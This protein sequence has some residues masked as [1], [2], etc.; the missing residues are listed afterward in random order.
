MRNQANFM[1]KTSIISFLFIFIA[2]YPVL[3]ETY[4]ADSAKVKII[5]D[6]DMGPDYDDIGAIALLH[7]FANQGKIEILATVSS[8]AHKDIPGTIEVYNKYFKRGDIPVGQTYSPLAPNFTAANNWN[9]QIIK[10][11]EPALLNKKY[12]SSVSIYRKVLA[13]QPDNSVTIVTVGFMTNISDLLQSKADKYSNLTGIELLEKKVKNWVAMAGGFPQGREFNI[14]EDAESG[15][16]AFDHF[17]KP[18]LFTGFEIGDKIKT[19]GKIAEQKLESSP[20]S[21][22]Y[23]I[24]LVSYAKEAVKAR[25]SWDQTAVLIAAENPE[26]YF[27]LSGPGTMKTEKDGSNY[28]EPSAQGKHKFIIHKYPY[29]KLEEVID[30]LMLEQPK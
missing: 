4:P 24:N 18:I 16:Y 10:K 27:Y 2:Q 9:E 6:T 14:H 8:D 17:P 7:A 25:S 28:W 30:K 26:K 13:E 3:S 23:Q 19:G 20:V 29:K 21:V 11:F 12:E 15:V 1:L 5:F 22:G